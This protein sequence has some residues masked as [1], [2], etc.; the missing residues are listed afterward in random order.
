M[1]FPPDYISNTLQL[2]FIMSIPQAATSLWF[3]FVCLGFF[4]ERYAKRIIVYSIVQSIYIV[5][6]FFL[7]PSW[8][9]MLHSQT[10]IFIFLAFLFPEAKIK[11]RLLIIFFMMAVSV[12]FDMVYAYISLHFGGYEH[13]L[14]NTV[15]FKIALFWP[16]FL[17]VA[18]ITLFLQHKKMYLARQIRNLVVHIRSKPYTTLVALIFLQLLLYML[19]LSDVFIKPLP[20]QFLQMMYIV[21][22]AIFLL[23]TIKIVQIIA[24][25]RLEGIHQSQEAYLGDLNKMFASIRGQRHDFANHVQVMYAMLAL[26]KHDQLRTYTEEVVSEIQ[27]M[28]VAVV[29]LP[30]PALAALIQAKSA[31]ALE[32]RIRFDYLIHTTS[33]T[34]SSVTNI[35]LVRM[36]G[37]LADYAF[38]EAVKLPPAEREVQLEMFVHNRELYITVTNRGNHLT[39]EEI[40]QFNLPGETAKADVHTGL[41]LANVQ[42]RAASYNGSVTVDSDLERGITFTI[43]IPNAGQAKTKPAK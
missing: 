10:S 20:I 30:S 40:A 12:I 37:N 1:T 39:R 18:L 8:A 34:F 22:I 25:A 36:I 24:Q 38:D 13:V 16:G 11:M 17:A 42:E 26:K 28:N 23:I 4:P 15:P 6:N 3:S 31:I 32:K 33:L 7:L 2:L 21:S 29:E 14:Y 35:D 41:G 5:G 27:S 43:K 9:Y 19:I